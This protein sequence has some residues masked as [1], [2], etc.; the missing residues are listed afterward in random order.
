MKSGNLQ[1]G[2]SPASTLPTKAIVFTQFWQHLLLI[3]KQLTAH[4]VKLAV[5]KG[6]MK[7]DEKAQ[8]LEHFKVITFF[9][10]TPCSHPVQLPEWVSPMAYEVDGRRSEPQRQRECY[11]GSSAFK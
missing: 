2:R 7:P 3:E 8:M 1:A 11:L 9:M 6:S 5:L 10:C 4:G